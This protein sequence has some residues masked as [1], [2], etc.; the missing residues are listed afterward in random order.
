VVCEGERSYDGPRRER[1]LALHAFVLSLLILV[2]VPATAG[3]ATVSVEPFAEP[4][5]INPFGSCGRYM[6]CPPDMVVFTGAPGEGNQ[7]TVTWEAVGFRRSR[8]V[9]RDEGAPLQAGQ[10]CE[11]LDAQAAACTAGAIGPMRLGDG[12]DRFVGSIVGT[13]AVVSGGDGDDTLNS[14]F[15]DMK[16]EAGADV[17]TGF[18]GSGGAGDDVLT[19][20]SGFG[21]TGDDVL[22]CGP[23]EGFCHFDGGP[24]DDRLTGGAIGDRLFGR[25]GDD[26]LRGGA[27]FDTLR[28]GLGDDRLV[29]GAGGDH[30]HG[31]S[32]ADRLVS[33][34]DRSAG[35]ARKLDR[36]D[37]GRGRRD[38][39]VADVTDDVKGCEHVVRPERN[40]ATGPV[41]AAAL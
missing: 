6:T 24:G 22:R 16:G 8:F 28:G 41:A 31:D 17:L 34:E 5:D 12:D 32:G 4:P 26:V 3:A 30:L 13:S 1:G 15:G 9:L 37:C 23:R 38:R 20:G 7:L 27:D 19:V 33:R 40:G 11:Q 21:G 14:D 18:R 25:R 10:G 2:A 35:M 29:G 36:V 39:A